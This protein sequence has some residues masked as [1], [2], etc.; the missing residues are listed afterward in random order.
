MKTLFNELHFAP[1]TIAM[2]FGLNLLPADISIS[3]KY[4]VEC[5][6]SIFGLLCN[7]RLFVG[8]FYVGQKPWPKQR[9]NEVRTKSINFPIV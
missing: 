3:S 5:R 9:L 8:V 1:S 4:D 2:E 7:S 6:L